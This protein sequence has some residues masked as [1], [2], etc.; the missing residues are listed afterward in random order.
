MTDQESKRDLTPDSLSLKYTSS[1]IAEMEGPMVDDLSEKTISDVESNN[2]KP[3]LQVGTVRQQPSVDSNTDPGVV[4]SD[5]QNAKSS[6]K[7]PSDRIASTDVIRREHG[8]IS[9]RTPLEEDVQT[10]AD[11][12][13]RQRQVQVPEGNVPV[14]RSLVHPVVD[15]TILD[16]YS[17]ESVLFDAV[18]YI[19]QEREQGEDGTGA[20][21]GES[22]SAEEMISAS[23]I[24]ATDLDVEMTNSD[25]TLDDIAESAAQTDDKAPPESGSDRG[26][27]DVTEL[28]KSPSLSYRLKKQSLLSKDIASTILPCI[29]EHDPKSTENELLLA[30]DLRKKSVANEVTVET[31]AATYQRPEGNRPSE[32]AAQ[33]A[34]P[35]SS[36]H[37]PDSIRPPAGHRKQDVATLKG[38]LLL[39]LSQKTVDHEDLAEIVHALARSH[40]L[41]HDTNAQVLNCHIKDSVDQIP[42]GTDSLVA[43]WSLETSVFIG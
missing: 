17:T 11:S 7:D 24:T 32:T 36:P 4:L 37:D 18:A 43:V 35:S 26:K 9:R 38:S 10:D 16:N 33:R 14:L 2:S 23:T 21:A 13:D 22:A 34:A 3:V 30:T 42:A 1:V 8:Y 41:K 27:Q 39:L 31:A 40:A 5:T 12:G 29:I 28:Q 6:A 15:T 20:G 25:G 19:T